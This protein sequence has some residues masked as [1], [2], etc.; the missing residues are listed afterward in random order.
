[1]RSAKH[2]QPAPHKSK[3]VAAPIK[4]AVAS[5]VIRSA[6][7]TWRTSGPDCATADS[8]FPLFSSP[9]TVSLGVS[10]APPH[11]YEWQRGAR[12]SQY[13]EYDRRILRRV[14]AAAKR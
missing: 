4:I 10:L 3:M 14:N 8:R 11:I 5:S 7:P 13:S 6:G 1:M 2:H 12:R 9:G